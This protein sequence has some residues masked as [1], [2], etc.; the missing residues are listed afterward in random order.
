[1]GGGLQLP[2]PAGQ[3]D[4]PNG[5]G[6]D[7][8]AVQERLCACAHPSVPG[9]PCRPHLPVWSLPHY[10]PSFL[11]SP[12]VLLCVSTSGPSPPPLPA[13]QQP[14][15]Q[16]TPNKRPWESLRKAHGPPAWVKKELEPLP[17]SPLEL[18][19]VEWEK[20]GATIPLVGQDIIDLQTEV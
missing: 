8:R 4:S 13:G 2:F 10:P 5:R 1:M 12:S 6:R 9:S 18:R 19:S 20:S 7:P 3:P 11:H 16:Q 15:K 17:P 14:E